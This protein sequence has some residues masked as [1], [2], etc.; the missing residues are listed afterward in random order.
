[1]IKIEQISFT[2]YKKIYDYY[3]HR[4][5]EIQI[6]RFVQKT[7]E[8]TNKRTRT[9]LH[10]LSSVSGLL[11]GILFPLTFLI[12]Q[13]LNIVLLSIFLSAH[14]VI[15]FSF[16]F[17]EII[18]L[19]LGARSLGIVRYG[20]A[21]SFNPINQ[22]IEIKWQNSSKEKRKLELDKISLEI[23]RS[24]KVM[25]LGQFHK[26]IEE[27]RKLS[28]ILN[29]SLKN[30][31]F[32]FLSGIILLGVVLV[33][34]LIFENLVVLGVICLIILISIISYKLIQIPSIPNNLAEFYETIKERYDVAKNLYV[35]IED[36][37]Q[38]SD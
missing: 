22:L 10:Q 38:S 14:G 16:I 35:G 36:F 11:F 15:F 17:S 20:P 21:P 1:M 29:F 19:F 25:K 23:K 33:G 26:T 12:D 24:D 28:R 30:S 3:I 37:L 7:F 32:I 9:Q 13:Y 8:K 31:R 4:W 6:L 5:D 2:R 18:P 34:H 27:N